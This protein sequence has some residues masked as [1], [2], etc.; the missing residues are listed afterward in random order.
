LTCRVPGD[1]K[2]NIV[3]YRDNK[4]L[5]PSLK[6]VMKYV[7][8]LATLAVRDFSERDIG[9]YRCDASN[10]LGRVE[11]AASVSMRGEW[12]FLYSPLPNRGC[13]AKA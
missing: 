8:G 10:A 12:R 9:R 11:S 7:E 13:F 2:P 1:P 6:Y 4:E 3:W 5:F